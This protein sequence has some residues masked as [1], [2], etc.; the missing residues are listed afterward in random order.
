MSRKI[1]LYIVLLFLLSQQCLYS[2][3]IDWVFARKQSIY[4]EITTAQL[5]FASYLDREKLVVFVCMAVL[6]HENGASWDWFLLH[7]KVLNE[8][9][10]TDL[11]I[12]SNQQRGLV[13]AFLLI[14]LTAVRAHCV[15]H[16]IQKVILLFENHK[17]VQS[18]IW[19]VARA[20]KVRKL[21]ETMQRI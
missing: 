15:Q 12:M 13:A 20:L 17:A 1:D 3:L 7:I 11:V 2:N 8:A 19:T 4:M 6:N 18:L 9:S 21:E 16:F 5:L 10:L 14:F